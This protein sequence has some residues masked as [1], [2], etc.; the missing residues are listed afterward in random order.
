MKVKKTD[1][2]NATAKQPIPQGEIVLYQPDETI[3]LEVRVEN[4]TVWLTQQQMADL[5]QTSRNNVTIHIGNIFKKGE[6]VVDSVRK[7]FLLTAA[8]GK[9]YHTKLYNID[10]VVAVGY[11][12]RSQRGLQLK[13]WLEQY[14]YESKID[15]SIMTSNGV[16]TIDSENNNGEIMLYQPDDTTRLEVRMDRETVWLTQTQ[17]VELF[18]SSK[19]NISD[20]INNIYEQGELLYEATVRNFRTVQKEGGRMVERLRTYYNLDTIISVGFRVNAKRGIKFRQWANGVIKNYMLR[21]YAINQQL[22]NMEQRID[23]KLDNQQGQIRQ[24]ESTL[25]DHQEKIDFFVRTSLPP[26]EGVFYDGQIFDAYTQ[27]SSLIKQAKKSIILIDNYIDETTLTLLNKRGA[28]IDATI[29]TRPLSQQQ[30][31]DVQRN[32]QQ[33]APVTVNIC[34]KNHDRFLIVDDEVYAFGASLKDAG[35]RLFAYIKMHETS[36]SDLIKSIR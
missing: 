16:Q 22:L 15:K 31:L 24:I 35:K 33:Y 21:G 7:D 12:I 6:L 2:R 34:K 4:D 19:S 3:S 13:Q 28:K 5:F 30:Q 10:A 26:V 1:M 18:Q 27:I 25:A 9:N 20:H 8:D 23:A 32:N 36:A 17:I 14:N 29:Y 11:R